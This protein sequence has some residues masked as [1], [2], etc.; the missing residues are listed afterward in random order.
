MKK[1]DLEFTRP[2]GGIALRQ[3]SLRKYGADSLQVAQD[4]LAGEDQE[5]VEQTF[6]R[7]IA[8]YG[9]MPLGSSAATRKQRNV[10]FFR[11]SVTLQSDPVDRPLE[12]LLNLESERLR[13]PHPAAEQRSTSRLEIAVGRI[14]VPYPDTERMLS[15]R[16]LGQVFQGAPIEVTLGSL[17]PLRERWSL[18]IHV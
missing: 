7:R 15:Y 9:T 3:L 11:L 16:E 18:P 13:Q 4:A 12:D 6:K 14:A 2:S 17:Q 1:N 5:G 10:R 8:K